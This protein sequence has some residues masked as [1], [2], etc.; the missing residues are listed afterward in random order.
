[1]ARDE[2]LN[3][4]QAVFWQPRILEPLGAYSDFTFTVTSIPAS[5]LGLP[6]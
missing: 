5:S 2:T 6:R 4:L 1:V 3:A